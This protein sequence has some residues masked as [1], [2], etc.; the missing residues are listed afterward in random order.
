MKQYEDNLPGTQQ[1]HCAGNSMPGVFTQDSVQYVDD[2]TGKTSNVACWAAVTIS[3]PPSYQKYFEDP[4][5]AACLLAP[6]EDRAH[7][8]TQVLRLLH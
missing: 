1:Y 2:G 3:P 4:Y 6:Y 5:V 7:T 8:V